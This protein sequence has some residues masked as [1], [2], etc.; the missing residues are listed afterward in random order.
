MSVFPYLVYL[1]LAAAMTSVA[2]PTA[3]ADSVVFAP[4]N[5]RLREILAMVNAMDH[6]SAASCTAETPD[7]NNSTLAFLGDTT[8]LSQIPISS[9][10]GGGDDT[11]WFSPCVS[12]NVTVTV[13]NGTISGPCATVAFAD[14]YSSTSRNVTDACAS[15]SAA[16][17][18]DL[19]VDPAVFDNQTQTLT[20]VYESSAA[21]RRSFTVTAICNPNADPSNLTNLDLQYAGDARWLRFESP[22]V[23]PGYVPATT[24]APATTTTTAA[25]A[26]M[27]TLTSGG[28][29]A[30]AVISVGVTI[31]SVVAA[32]ICVRRR[33]F[34][35]EASYK[36][37]EPAS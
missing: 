7:G 9:S 24:V 31:A 10:T 36:A 28:I 33:R 34:G 22:T 30:I 11:L 27:L 12:T 5:P 23:C 13:A 26:V 1:V 21:A 17:A 15:L 20:I 6:H 18:F 19:I 16:N 4:L 29:A 8:L 2:T 25:P 14:S 32:V 3:A 37:L 35:F